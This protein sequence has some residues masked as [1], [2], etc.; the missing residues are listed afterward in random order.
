MKVELYPTT[1]YGELKHG[2]CFL[3]E[4]EAYMKLKDSYDDS[5]TEDYEFAH[6]IDCALRFRDCKLVEFLG[7]REVQPIDL[8][9]VKI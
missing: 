8:K 3:Y 9:V 7:V 4:N 6:F 2:E 5:K 1:K